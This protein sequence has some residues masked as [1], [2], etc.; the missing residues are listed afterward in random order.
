MNYYSS[1]PTTTVGGPTGNLYSSDPVTSISAQQQQSDIYRHQNAQQQQQQLQQQ[2]QQGSIYD[3]NNQLA[4]VARGNQLMRVPPFS[5]MSV[6][7]GIPPQISGLA[8]Q[9]PINM[10]M[11]GAPGMMGLPGGFE[12]PVSASEAID[13]ELYARIENMKKK[14]SN[15][16]PFVLKLSRYGDPARLL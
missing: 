9:M 8:P 12:Q 16:P 2:Q 1:L 4:R 6:A 7:P 14:R 15:I 13:R 11:M 3:G 5:G 10:S